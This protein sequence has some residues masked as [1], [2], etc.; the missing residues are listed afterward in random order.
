MSILYMSSVLRTAE[1][2]KIQLLCHAIYSNSPS[3]IIRYTHTV[4]NMCTHTYTG[5]D[6]YCTVF[7]YT[8]RQHDIKDSPR[9]IQVHPKQLN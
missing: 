6:W 5:S 7:M 3:I 4:Y 2:N 9:P 1:H 8:M